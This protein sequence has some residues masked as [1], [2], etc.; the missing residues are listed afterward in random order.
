VNDDEEG[1][2]VL[3][4]GPVRTPL[5]VSVY[6]DRECTDLALTLNVLA[7]ADTVTL[8]APCTLRFNEGSA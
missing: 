4:Y 1:D 3:D 7:G 8:D 5:K 2:V 6:R